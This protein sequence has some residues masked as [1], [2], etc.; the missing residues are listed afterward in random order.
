[1]DL[2]EIHIIGPKTREWIVSRDACPALAGRGFDA[3]GVSDAS[4]PY[5]MLR[6]APRQW[7]VLACLSGSGWALIEGEWHPC[8]RGQCYVSPPGRAMGFHPGRGR[9]R[10]AWMFH[11]S[12]SSEAHAPECVLRETDTDLFANVITGLHAELSGTGD[13][14][15][16]GA[17][18]QLLETAFERVTARGESDLRLTSLWREVEGRPGH[19]WT[20]GQLARMAGLSGEQFRRVCI[21]ETG[22]SPM[23]QVTHL[24]MRRAAHLLRHS[25]LKVGAVA[26]EVGYS[27]P[28]A[29]STAFRRWSGVAPVVHAGIRE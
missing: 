18:V 10:F 24:R 29:F 9:W 17:W 28:F 23:R 16:C 1:M 21:A 19:P 4:A 7:H 25:G 2:R 22:R 8:R 27:D 12:G 20:A 11:R 5:R 14:A 26:E 15:V 13:P 3:V 6:P